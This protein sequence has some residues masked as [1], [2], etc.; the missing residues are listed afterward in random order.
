MPSPWLIHLSVIASH[1]LPKTPFTSAKS[2]MTTVVLMFVGVARAIWIK[3]S[4]NSFTIIIS[5]NVNTYIAP[6][7]CEYDQIRFKITEI[8]M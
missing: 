1:E 3:V 5:N 7:K 8:N 4:N 6:Y 2:K